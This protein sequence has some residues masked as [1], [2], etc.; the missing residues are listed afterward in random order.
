MRHWSLKKESLAAWGTLIFLAGARTSL[1]FLVA[2][3]VVVV[4]SAAASSVVVATSTSSLVLT[5]DVL[6]RSS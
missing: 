5:I 4:A 1:G 6:A 3:L 2:G